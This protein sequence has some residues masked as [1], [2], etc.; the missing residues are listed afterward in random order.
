MN[1][2]KYTE[3]K[4]KSKQAFKKIAAVAEVKDT[5]NSDGSIN[6]VGTPSQEAYVVLETKQYDTNTGEEK[7]ASTIKISLADL[8]SNKAQLTNEKAKI[9]AELTEINTMITDIKAL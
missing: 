7:T 3:L 9:D 5:F 2:A 6:K 8:E 4:G 1:Y